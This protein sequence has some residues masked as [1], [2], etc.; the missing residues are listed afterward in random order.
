[1]ENRAGQKQL[2]EV[3]NS[4]G[5]EHIVF[6]LWGP[7]MTVQQPAKGWAWLVNN[8]GPEVNVGNVYSDGVRI[9]ESVRRG[10]FYEWDHP[11]IRWLAE[12]RPS[13]DWWKM[14]PPPYDVYV[15][16]YGR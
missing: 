16:K 7:S 11:Y 1:M 10:T 12:G 6:E 2:L 8:F 14:E 15:D 9:L 5:E 3:A 4:V 13:K